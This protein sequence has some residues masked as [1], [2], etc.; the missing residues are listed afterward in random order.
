MTNV[1]STKKTE[2]ITHNSLGDIVLYAGEAKKRAFG[3]KHIIFSRMTDGNYNKT[4]DEIT[5]ILALIGSALHDGKSEKSG[6]GFRII[7]N[8]IAAIIESRMTR[9]GQEVFL[10]SGYDLVSQKKEAT[11]AIQT[12]NAKYSFALEY[13]LL[14]KQVVAV[15][16]NI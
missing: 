4:D 1:L 5:A 13:S 9:R 11:G 10:L 16:S 2:I 8:G 7:K 3:L 15:T 12:V 14:R 6:D